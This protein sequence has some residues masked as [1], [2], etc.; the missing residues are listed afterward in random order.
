MAKDAMG[1]SDY[2]VSYSI[3]EEDRKQRSFGSLLRSVTGL[4]KPQASETTVTLQRYSWEQNEKVF[5]EVEPDQL[6]PGL[7][8]VKV[9]ITD[10]TTGAAA[11]KEAVL[12]VLVDSAER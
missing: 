1:M 9:T 7:K 12:W 10:N 11:E 8:R 6:E 2:T 5:F 4:G 3:R